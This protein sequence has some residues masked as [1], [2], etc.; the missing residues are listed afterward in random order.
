MLNEKREFVLFPGESGGYSGCCSSRNWVRR[1][2]KDLVGG[3][4]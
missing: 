2:L 4:Y 1:F 3:V